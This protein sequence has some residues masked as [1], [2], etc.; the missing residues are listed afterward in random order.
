MII[1]KGEKSCF[2]PA[3]AEADNGDLYVA[4]GVTNGFHQD[5]EM[6]IFD[7]QTLRN[8]KS[9][10][11]IAFG[12]GHQDRVNINAKPAL[13]FDMHD[14][15]WISYESNRNNKRMEDGDNYTGDHCCAI[16][17]YQNGKIVETENIEKWLFNS[18][19]DHKPTFFMD[20]EGHVYLTTHCEGNFSDPY[21]K[22]RISWLDPEL[23]WQQPVTFLKT[24]IKGLLIPPAVVFDSKGA[25]WFATCLKKALIDY[26][27]VKNE[28]IKRSRL[29][30]LH[31]M[32]FTAPKLSNKYQ[33]LAF[34]TSQVK[35]YLPDAYN[36][37][38]VS[39]H[40]R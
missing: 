10:P 37:N 13:V 6:A 15:L 11:P 8:K 35:E 33:P 26:K 36:I 23:E 14:N 7:D 12:G 17:S 9:L 38:T 21:W 30:E 19:N 32:Q 18:N 16:L 29:S 2:D 22:Y 5:I 40:P 4:F 24:G 34:R 1:D 25:F 27:P 31:V 3:L 39:G 28:D 20:L